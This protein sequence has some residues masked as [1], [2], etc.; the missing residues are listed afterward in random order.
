VEISFDCR[1]AGDHEQKASAGLQMV[2][3]LEITAKQGWTIKNQ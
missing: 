1:Q 2:L 3:A